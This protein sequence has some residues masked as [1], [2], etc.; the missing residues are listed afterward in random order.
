MPPD[1]SALWVIKPGFKTVTIWDVD[2][3]QSTVLD[4]ELERE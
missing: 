1:T 3:S 4:I 2:M